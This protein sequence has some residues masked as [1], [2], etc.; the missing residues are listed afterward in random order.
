MRNE[1]DNCVFSISLKTK[2]KEKEMKQNEKKK[3]ILIWN[4][5]YDKNWVYIVY[6]KEGLDGVRGGGICERY[7]N[8]VREREKESEWE[9]EREKNL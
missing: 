7:S 2:M 3:K 6:G 5:F 9:I 1:S 8:K 4:G